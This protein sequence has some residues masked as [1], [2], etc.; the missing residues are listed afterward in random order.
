MY[1]CAHILTTYNQV[2]LVVEKHD[3]FLTAKRLRSFENF[4]FKN[5]LC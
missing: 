1:I 2:K 3:G 5:M 4:K